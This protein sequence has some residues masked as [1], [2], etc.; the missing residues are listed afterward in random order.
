MTSTFRATIETLDWRGMLIQ[1]SYNPDW[2]GM[3]M[4][5]HLEIET[6]EPV[7]APLPMTETGYRSHFLGQCIVEDAGGPASY[8]LAWLEAA[9][10]DRGWAIIEA[11]SRQLALF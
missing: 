1:I 2:S 3:R 7:R 5:A 6:Q 8:V 4:I 11:E 9:A 10:K